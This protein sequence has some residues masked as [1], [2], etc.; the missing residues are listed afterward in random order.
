MQKIAK[1]ILLKAFNRLFDA[2]RQVV[3]LSLGILSIS[4]IFVLYSLESDKELIGNIHLVLCWICSILSILSGLA[5]RFIAPYVEMQMESQV[6]VDGNI[7][8]I[9]YDGGR[10]FVLTGMFSLI[11]FLVATGCFLA[12]GIINLESV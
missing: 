8:K 5:F 3:H 1:E 7:P 12:F 10:L 2:Q 4:V 6:R 9:R 11:S